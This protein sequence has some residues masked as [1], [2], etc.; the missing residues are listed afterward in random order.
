M[1]K[2]IRI[3]QVFTTL[4]RGGAETNMMNY[5]R[6]MNLKEFE[7]D[8]LVHRE[9]KGAYEDEVQLHGSKVFRLPPVHPLH[10]KSY[11]KAVRRFFDDHPDYD[12]V[13]GQTS[14]LGVF[15]Y[16]EAKRR[17][18]P[19]IIAHAHLSTM[20][21]D[22]KAL[23]RLLWRKRTQQ[24]ANTFFTCGHDAAQWLF[25]KQAHLAFP[26]NNAIEPAV[27][28][29]DAEKRAAMRKALQAEN[30]F[31]LVNVARFNTQ[32][33]HRFLIRVFHALLQHNDKARLFLVG[34]G[35]LEADV[36]Q[37]VQS[38]GLQDHVVFLGTR[39]DVPELLQAMDLFV[40]PSL[41]EGLPVSLVEAQATGVRAVVSDG[42]SEE[43]ILVEENVKVISLK[44]SPA[45]W[46][47]EILP[48]CGYERK[49]TSST[50]KEKG[51]DIADAVKK[52]EAQYRKLLHA[53]S[54][55]D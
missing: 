34:T 31:N 46:A 21:F 6:H 4:N 43:A 52:L 8:F 39:S 30:T 12:I 16:E 7:M 3:L 32:K 42:I 53:A 25:G 51:Y 49:E 24:A 37:Q 17:K 55:K 15:I 2:P 50:I 26:M 18:I 27:F 36:R 44:K 38:L 45:A 1:E 48:F 19:V 35:D 23:F 47:E 33:N 22:H 40:F 29:F 41:F 10:L 28:A 14:E 9:E 5:I 11:K 13:H 20:N 54:S